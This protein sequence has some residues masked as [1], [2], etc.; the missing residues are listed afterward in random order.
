[1]R[2]NKMVCPKS[3]NVE[4]IFKTLKPVTQTALVAVNNA[5]IK[6]I[7][8]FEAVGSISK[9]APIKISTKKLPTKTMAGL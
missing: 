1:M 8:P 3:V 4:D 6:V 9:K 5:S 7:E 2:H